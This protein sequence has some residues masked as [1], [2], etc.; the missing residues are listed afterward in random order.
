MTDYVCQLAWEHLGVLPEELEKVANEIEVLDIITLNTSPSN[1]T[2]K[3]QK[4]DKRMMSVMTEY[5]IMCSII[6]TFRRSGKIYTCRKIKIG[7][8]WSMDRKTA[9]R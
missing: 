8:L 1:T 9:L 6:Q 5:L 7:C 3:C 4:N 2:N